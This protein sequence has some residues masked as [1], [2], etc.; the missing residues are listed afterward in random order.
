M[1]IGISEYAGKCGNG[2]YAFDLNPHTPDSGMRMN[3]PGIAYIAINKSANPH[4][5]LS[6][7]FYLGEW[8]YYSYEK[9][10]RCFFHGVSALEFTP[11]WK[12]LGNYNRFVVPYL[13]LGAGVR[14]V[15]MTGVANYGI[16]GLDREGMYELNIP[17]GLGLTIRL[18][19]RLSLNLQSAFVWTSSR[20]SVEPNNNRTFDKAMNQTAGLIFN[21]FDPIACQSGKP[22]LCPPFGRRSK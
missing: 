11:R 2:F 21:L 22:I 18:Y 1:G 16:L 4:L 14:R 8:G 5:D 7:R 3:Q 19:K 13:T 9:P 6:L 10:G 12:F 15:Q 20:V 17:I